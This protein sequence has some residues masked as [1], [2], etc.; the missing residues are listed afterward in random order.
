MQKEMLNNI[1]SYGEEL[2]EAASPLPKMP[3]FLKAAGAKE[4]VAHGGPWTPKKSPTHWEIEINNTLGTAF[5]TYKTFIVDFYPTSATEGTWTAN[6]F[7]KFRMGNNNKLLFAGKYK[8]SGSGKANLFG[9]ALSGV[10]LT[11][12]DILVPRIMTYD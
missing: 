8:T 11:S 2:N 7:P 12:T 5:S 1:K 6:L 4:A 9:R 10:E 3:A